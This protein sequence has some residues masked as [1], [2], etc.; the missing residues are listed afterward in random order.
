M[1]IR[2]H[3]PSL[4]LL[5]A[6][7]AVALAITLVS[8]LFGIALKTVAS[9]VKTADISAQLG[10]RPSLPAPPT[11][12][13]D[14]LI[15]GSDT[16]AGQGR[17]Y[18]Q[19]DY[20]NVA[21]S[22]TAL[23]VHIYEDRKRVLVVS[24]P[25]DTIV[26]IPECIN[27]DGK[28]FPQITTRF[29][30][31]FTQGGPGC[32]VKTLETITGMTI[33]HFAVV[34]FLGFKSVVDALGGV[35]VCIP[36]DVN[37]NKSKL[38]V[39]AGLQTL[40]GEASL[41]YVRTRLGLG[42]GGDISR[43]SR[44]QDFLKSMVR[45]TT[46]S[47][48]LLDP[49]R[50]FRT[51]SEVAKSLTTDPKLGSV[52]KMT[53]LAR[54]LAGIDPAKIRFMTAPISTNPKDRNTL[55]FST[56]ESTKL[57]NALANDQGYEEPIELTEDQIPDVAVESVSVTVLNGTS[58]PGAASE[59]ASK[60][61]AE[62]FKIAET[63]NA[64]ASVETTYI[65]ANKEQLP[66]ARTLAKALGNNVKIEIQESSGNDIKLFIGT[67]RATVIGFPKIE[68]KTSTLQQPKPTGS[69]TKNPCVV[70]N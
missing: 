5:S 70:K 57:W 54:S 55:V 17:K 31:A 24:I 37:D 27:S 59:V 53:A 15:M 7:S 52:E 69:D 6:M 43:I 49:I 65:R 19:P 63:R 8:G 42:D 33:E 45:K 50:L 40:D 46:S 18:G 3:R 68:E 2:G 23:L 64:P 16:R 47:Q 1:Q 58:I 10:E 41:A 56:I 25:R 66:A 4:V 35:E 21:R 67:N 28:I 36:Q 13:I 30:F 12:P 32:T 61:Q 38:F 39:K 9:E 11:G 29:N 34:D 48:V 22:D 60:L 44:Q 51:L 20:Y 26:R 62:G 14:I